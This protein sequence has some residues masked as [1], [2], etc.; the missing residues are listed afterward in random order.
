MS[1]SGATAG[2]AR[3]DTRHARPVPR[4]RVASAALLFAL[5]LA[6]LIGLAEWLRHPAPP[7]VPAPPPADD[8]REP[9]DC[10]E[11][12]PRED[13]NDTPPAVGEG[14]GA[15]VTVTS[16]DLYDC[17][18]YFD[19]R[20]VRYSGE[21]VGGVLQ[22]RD[23]AW[24]QLNDDVYAGQP[25]P[26]PTHRHYRGANSGVGVWLPS[27]LAGAITNVGGPGVRGDTLTIEGI[28]WQVDP[29]AFEAAVLRA[30]R[31]SLVR[32]GQPTPDP[33]LRN[34]MVVAAALA[35][36]AVAAVWA[37]ARHTRRS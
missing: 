26:L 16:D 6:G 27:E 4:A 11:P 28:F 32:V 23:G 7:H 18:A 29:H 15:P 8:P 5:F 3:V 21:V 22:R 36:A 34:R 1:R 13:G 20:R 10:P 24:V 31:G 19:G 37:Q 25:G 17:P 35:L 9:I 12:L 2:S 30:E 14:A 33:P